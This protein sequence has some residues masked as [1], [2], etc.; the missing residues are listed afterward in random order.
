MSESGLVRVRISPE[1]SLI[2]CSRGIG[3]VGVR[4]IYKLG[5]PRSTI[6]PQKKSMGRGLYDVTGVPK[7][8]PSGLPKKSE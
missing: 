7:P 4:P 1:N 8:P 2:L 6:H 5:G 3:G